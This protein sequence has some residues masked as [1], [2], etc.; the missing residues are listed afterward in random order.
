MNTRRIGTE[1][2][3]AACGYLEQN[4]VR[5]VEKNFR[6]RQGEIDM[7]GY[8]KDYLVFFEVKYRKDDA[9]G[10]AA[11]A[12]GVRKQKKIC[13]VSDYYRMIHGYADDTPIRFDVIAID[14]SNIEWF[15]NAFLYS[16]II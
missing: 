14:G 12:V 9:K 16:G 5:I 4:G 8:D 1:K 11:Q 3:E 2:E 6:C 13:R 10:N 15:Q 7:I